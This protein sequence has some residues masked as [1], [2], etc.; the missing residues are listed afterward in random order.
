MFRA[1]SSIGKGALTL[2]PLIAL[3]T[4]QGNATA[5]G[6]YYLSELTFSS[7]KTCRDYDYARLQ[8]IIH[9]VH[10]TLTRERARKKPHCLHGL[11][12]LKSTAR[13]P[14]TKRG[15]LDHGG[16]AKESVHPDTH[17]GKL[18]RNQEC[19]CETNPRGNEP[20]SPATGQDEESRDTCAK[21]QV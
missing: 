21:H 2:I 17:H 11:R 20:E 15:D 19:P 9:R 16:G 14:R 7:T 13:F 12:H 3:L 6:V 5:G 4:R 8:R 18:T 1:P 10:L